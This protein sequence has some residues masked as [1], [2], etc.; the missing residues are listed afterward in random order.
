MPTILLGARVIILYPY[1]KVL[2]RK[3]TYNKPRN[4]N[5][6][7]IVFMLNKQVKGRK[8]N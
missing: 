1:K 3:I 4:K 8:E 7:R 5:H 2:T 6:D